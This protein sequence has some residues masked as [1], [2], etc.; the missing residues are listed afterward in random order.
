[1]TEPE[2]GFTERLPHRHPRRIAILLGACLAVIVGAAV[3]MG[4]S[5]S[6]SQAPGATAKPEVSGDPGT[7]NG[8]LRD[9]GRHGAFGG[10]FG[11]LLGGPGRLEGLG[12]GAITITSISGS[13]ISLETVDGW[14]RTIAVTSTTT[15]TK[16]G[17]TIAVGDLAVGDSIRFSQTRNADG[18]FT[19]DA[20]HVV[21]PSVAGTVTAKTATSITV[22]TRDGASATI[23]VDGDTKYEVAGVTDADLGDVAVG[24]RIVAAGSRNAD[25]SLDA[26]LV[27]AGN[28]R[29]RGGPWDHDK[30]GGPSPS[31]TPSPSASPG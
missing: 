17:Q 16:G 2:I 12:R 9:G 22:Q 28:E 10:L 15:I 23:H 6:P 31:A 19:V 29:L 8:G 21:L 7:P 1:M 5:P 30:A 18:S 27:H 3:T 24:M 14:T 13:S 26:D 25:G 4:A 20:I 11:G